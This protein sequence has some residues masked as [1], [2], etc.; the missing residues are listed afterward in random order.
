MAFV[1]VG[2]F[3]GGAIV[4]FG[5]FAFGIAGL[6]LMTLLM[7][8]H[9]RQHWHEPELIKPQEDIR[10][11]QTF[12]ATF[13]QSAKDSAILPGATVTADLVCREWVR[14]KAG[15]STHTKKSVRRTIPLSPVPSADD[16][17]VVADLTIGVPT[18]LPPSFSLP[19]NKLSWFVAASVESPRAPDA[20]YEFEFNVIPEFWKP[21]AVDASGPVGP[22][23]FRPPEPPEWGGIHE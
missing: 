10:L 7:K 14:Y 16:L 18:D 15:S 23:E 11:G 4:V 8:R 2:A 19:N 17:A 9:H 3:R 5:A 1:I 13:R 6:V 20:K 22:N 12:V 21:N